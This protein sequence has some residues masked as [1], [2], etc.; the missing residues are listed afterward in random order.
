DPFDALGGTQDATDYFGHGTEVAG[1]AA[2]S[3]A[4]GG[5][6][7][8]IS[9]NSP[10]MPISVYNRLGETS[11]E[12]VVNG[13]RW[14]A[15][16]GAAAI[17][18]ANATR[19]A[20][21]TAAETAALERAVTD[22]FARGSVVV[23]SAGNEGTS[24]ADLPAVLPH[25][26]TVGGSSL[27]G[28]RATFSNFAP[29]L[30]LVSPATALV[31]PVGP[32]LCGSGYATANGAAFAPPA[33]AGA[34]ALLAQLRPELTPQQRVDLLRSSATDVDPAGWDQETGFGLLNVQ[35][36]ATANPPAPETSQE[37]DDDPAY[38]RGAG[39]ATHPT[40]LT[41]TLTK[42][43]VGAVS[44]SK[45]PSDVYR[46]RLKKGDR[47]VASA[48]VSGDGVVFL[49]LWKPTVGDYDVSNE[50]TKQQIVSSGG[51]SPTPELKMRVTKTGTYY[52]SVEAQD[53]ID[54]DDP[55][56]VAPARE[57]YKMTLS[58]KHLKTRPAPKKK[59]RRKTTKKR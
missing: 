23:A 15:D 25:V 4:A 2:G 51:F 52:V 29:W 43:V 45:D 53:P 20:D 18:V 8:G 44:P 37:V 56:D 7:H 1:I 9:P 34:L 30:D 26:L 27:Q 58:R 46:V 39:A 3:T 10:V 6:V 16:H 32:K 21:A 57:P 40:Y 49:G 41:K 24:Q 17:V 59:P 19:A 54:P 47:F 48:T 55:E 22:A 13:I 12:A 28:L 14:A 36:A 31:A 5:L 42:R 50:V 35:K 11:N 33:A 38:V